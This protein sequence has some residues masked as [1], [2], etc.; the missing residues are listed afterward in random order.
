MRSA[1]DMKR[2][3]AQARLDVHP[4]SDERVFAD[5][6]Q[7]R[8]QYKNQE[9][10]ALSQ[11]RIAMR[12]PIAK[13][14]VA[15][16]IVVA[17]AAGLLMW[18][19]TQSPV[20][21]AD[22]LSH[23]NQ[24]SVYTYRMDMTITG[25]LPGG[26]E[27]NQDVQCTALASQDL[28]LKMSMDMVDAKTGLEM[29]QVMYMLP[30]K[31]TMLTINPKQKMYTEVELNDTLLQR[32]R[33]ENNNP[34]AMIEQILGCD[35][36]SLG[37]STIEG[38][39]VEGFQTTDPNYMGNIM[40]QTDVTVWVDVETQL[41]VRFEMDIQAND[42]TRMQGVMHDFQWDASVDAAEFDPV[43]PPD[44]IN[45]MG[46]PMK[47]PAN[48]EETAIEGLK[49]CAELS[50]EYPEKLDMMTLMSQMEHM[51][52][53]ETSN[54]KKEGFKAMMGAVK[55]MT[56]NI[57]QVLA[58]GTFYSTLTSD[59][60]APAYYGDVVT[61]DDVDQVLM[62]WKVSDTEYRVIFGNLHAETVSADVLAELEKALPVK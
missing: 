28:G 53:S 25:T 41:P 45:P 38:I 32:Q 43:I 19:G 44:Y 17:G 4:E 33:K 30:Q 60:K 40:G 57:K 8:S 61:P 26:M 24:I 18:S 21:L 1:D 22:V 29:S 51:A 52:K 48:N 10:M 49:L 13:L 27:M 46:G 31:K 3:F 62:R 5:V 15:A 20:A 16:T 50:G 47:M 11:W 34:A 36:Q 9:K 37:R 59:N 7:A 23:I 12:S 54:D 14:A 42:T 2:L 56:E 35:Y 39:E 55:G 6:A 58:V